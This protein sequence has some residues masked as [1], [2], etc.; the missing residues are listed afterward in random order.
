M[1]V[2]GDFN[3]KDSLVS[4]GRIY[5]GTHLSMDKV[6]QRRAR[7]V[8][9]EPVNSGDEVLLDVDGETP[10]RLPATFSVMPGA[11]NIV[12]PA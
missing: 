10:G 5:K 4:G 7:I 2:M 1:V 9:A 6:S 12:A 11:L 8:H 3:L